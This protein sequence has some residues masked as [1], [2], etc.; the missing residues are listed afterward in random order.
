VWR[1]ARSRAILL[2]PLASAGFGFAQTTVP[3]PAPADSVHKLAPFEVGADSSTGYVATSTLGGTLIRTNLSDVGSAISVYTKDFLDDLGAFD[4]ETLRAF[5]VN[6]DVGGVQGTFV[7][8]TSQ[9]AENDNFGAGNSNTRIRG[10]AAADNTLNY[11][12]SDA[13]WDGYNTDRIDVIRGANSILFG[14]GS[15]AGI[16]NASWVRALDRNKG[17]TQ[18]RLDQFGTVRTSLDYNQVLKKSELSLRLALLRDDQKFK[19]EPS[20]KKDDRIYLTTKIAPRFLQTQNSTFK[21]ELA[22]EKGDVASNTRRAQPP[23]D[24]ITPFFL[25]PAQGGLG[26]QTINRRDPAD[27]RLLYLDYGLPGQRLNPMI[28]SAWGNG[29]VVLAYDRTAQPT[30]IFEK[31]INSAWGYRING[32]SASINVPFQAGSSST[33]IQ[34]AVPPVFLQD[35]GTYAALQ[36]RPFAARY[37]TRALTDTK[38]FNFYENLIDGN[39]K[40]ELRDWTSG[41][42]ELTHSFF[43]NKLSYNLQ[44][45]KESMAFDRYAALGTT[46]EIEIDAGK[47]LPDGRPNP[48]AGK[49]FVGASPFNGS[50]AEETKRDATRGML[51]FE[52]DFGR[53]AESRLGR[54]LGRHFLTGTV[55]QQRMEKSQADYLSNGLGPDWVNS[56]LVSNTPNRQDPFA[57]AALT[58]N[59][60]YLSDSLAGRQL[61]QDLGIRNIGPGTPPVTGA[62]N[63]RYFDAHYTRFNP[64]VAPNAVDAEYGRAAQNPANYV[65]WTNGQVQIYGAPTDLASRDY[66]TRARSYSKAH[67]DSKAVTWQGS[68]LQGAL[69]GTYGWREDEYRTW[70]YTWDEL[71]ENLVDFRSDRAQFHFSPLKKV[72]TA[73]SWSA[74]F[75]ADKPLRRLPFNVALLYGRG[76]NTNPDPGRLSIF[77][78]PVL[79]A[80]GATD[81]TSVVL[82]TRDNTWM[83]R[84]TRFRT[85]VKNASSS[86]TLQS[87]KFR[88]VQAFTAGMQGV[89]RTLV[90]KEV[91]FGSVDPVLVAG[92]AAGTLD[93]TQRAQLAAQRINIPKNVSAANAWLDFERRFAERF[94]HAVSAWLSPGGTFPNSIQTPG[95]LWSF[96]EDAVLLED[97]ESKGFEI[98]LVAN[99]TRRWR[100]SA[101]VSRTQASREN[102]PGAQVQQVMDFVNREF[103]TEVGL[104]PIAVNTD[105]A[106]NGANNTPRGRI[107]GLFDAYQVELQ[108]NG[109]Q[110]R[111]LSEW[112]ANLVTNYRFDEG[113]LKGFSLGASYRYE[114]PK[115]VGYGYKLND[116]GAIAVDLGTKY[117]DD[118]HHTFGLSA[119]YSRRLSSRL[120][121]TI[122]VNVNNA[123]Q[124][125]DELAVTSTQPDGSIRTG[126]I[127]EGRSWAL[128]NT[129]DF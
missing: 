56:R 42:A 16:I 67:V 105:G 78:A 72:G 35:Y 43:D 50:R 54:L 102:L 124:P 27:N 57:T 24:L 31:E 74:A 128:T 30:A 59:Y 64:N 18:L 5:T 71:R 126:M 48:N 1:R 25:P 111:E 88:M 97:T 121:W 22:V 101:N 65:G 69:V 20:F 103:E 75:H 9:G 99:P 77:N 45:F 83:L 47:L 89:Y 79:G 110:V 118:A 23:F 38:I 46:S 6:T 2:F 119:R 112:R 87:Q 40:R 19:Q 92:E 63:Y 37:G 12:K 49:A 60:F 81:D 120:G 129:F 10:L 11:F 80:T 28:T 51:F 107:A 34:G 100:L 125:H 114:S 86:S 41:H 33:S 108:N 13:P 104:V 70:L 14:L 115:V 93:A 82:S 39:S 15:P 84:A 122:Q 95:T 123:L 76:E 62:Y 91:R 29:T 116:S 8:A 26:G 55:S 106:P 109:Q 90:D 94:P 17:R 58:L 53:R 44:F 3:T 61:G 7:N 96:P 85:V 127:R 73:S 66:L 98:E 68:F 117:K 52:H 113:R 36:N 21:L 4:N 32:T